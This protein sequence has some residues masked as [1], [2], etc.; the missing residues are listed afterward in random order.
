MR[1]QERRAQAS[2]APGAWLFT[3]FSQPVKHDVGDGRKA[4]CAARIAT[5]AEFS[6]AHVLSS[7]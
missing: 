6:L 5:Q 2:H 1:E 7:C 3:Y 4:T